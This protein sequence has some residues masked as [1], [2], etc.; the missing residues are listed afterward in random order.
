MIRAQEDTV[1]CE[2]DKMRS[3]GKIVHVFVAYFFG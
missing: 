2:K 1:V 3:V